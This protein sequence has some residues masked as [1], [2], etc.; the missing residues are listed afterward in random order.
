[1]YT[2]KVGKDNNLAKIFKHDT[3]ENL[4]YFALEELVVYILYF[5]DFCRL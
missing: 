4:S 1:M 3:D 5:S 2:L